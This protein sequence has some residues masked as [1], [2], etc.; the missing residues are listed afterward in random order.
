MPK[1]LGFALLALAIVSCTDETPNCTSGDRS[2]CVC[3]NGGLGV[4]VCSADTWGRCGECAVPE[5]TLGPSDADSGPGSI[6]G[7][8]I[9]PGQID[10]TGINIQINGLSDRDTSTSMTGLYDFED[11]PAGIYSVAASRSGYR[12]VVSDVFEVI[13]ETQTVVPTIVLGDFTGSFSGVVVLGDSEDHTGTVVMVRGTGHATLTDET[14]R[15]SIEGVSPG[16][17]SVVASHDGYFPTGVS[18]QLA[19]GGQVTTVPLLSLSTEPGRVAGEV[20]FSATD[21][22]GVAV[23][24]TAEWDERITCNGVTNA[25]GFFETNDCTP[26]N[27]TVLASHP[28]YLTARLTDIPVLSG[29]VAEVTIPIVAEGRRPTAIEVFSGSDQEVSA[30]SESDDFEV[31]I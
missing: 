6:Q 23:V 30:G 13:P 8:A 14:G 22:S 26:G 21:R 11:V 10:H 19:R 20:L 15:W 16:G 31:L 24:A 4:Q 25:G 3:E 28:D 18:D 29:A 9:L 17:Y 12:E 1:V 5:V 2:L 27:Y 7:I